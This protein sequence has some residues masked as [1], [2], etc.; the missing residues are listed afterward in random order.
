MKLV[1][2]LMTVLG[3][4]ASF[5]QGIEKVDL[6]AV[7]SPLVVRFRDFSTNE[8]L[9][10]ILKLLMGPGME[11]ALSDAATS[12]YL[13]YSN[14]PR[15]LWFQP[16]SGHFSWSD[17]V[18][19]GPAWSGPADV[20]PDDANKMW[21]LAEAFVRS[22]GLLSPY[23]E[24][25]RERARMLSVSVM[26]ADDK[27]SMNLSVGYEVL[28]SRTV[29]GWPLL[30]GSYAKVRFCSLSQICG[31]E[32]LFRQ[33]DAVESRQMRPQEEILDSLAAEA[34][35]QLLEYGP[36]ESEPML[37]PRYGIYCRGK[38][39]HQTV[40]YPVMQ[41][42]ACDKGTGCL[43]GAVLLAAL[44]SDV[45]NGPKLVPIP[46]HQAEIDRFNEATGIEI[47]PPA[48]CGGCK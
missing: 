25:S 12:E 19:D 26:S 11:K 17:S 46:W 29:M 3:S 28:F 44:V 34:L 21:M 47:V 30:G 13:F 24:L 45:A 14:G 22:L 38:G 7:P 39:E 33:I 36:L 32:V 27:P 35:L 1:A 10:R 40:G 42:K 48:G 2:V 18:A 41:V 8:D 4:S 16:Q 5:A 43:A 6:G 15:R 31:G 23:E 37:P 20:G 9:R